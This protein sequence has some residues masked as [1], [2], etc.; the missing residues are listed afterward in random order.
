MSDDNDQ[1]KPGPKEF[2]FSAFPPNTAFHER[3]TGRE[4]RDDASRGQKPDT[5][6]TLPV[7]REHRT[8]KERRRRIDPTT[9]EKQY[10]VEETEFMNAMQRFKESTGKN[11][12]TYGEVLKVATALGYRRV[13]TDDKPSWDD[14]IDDAQSLAESSSID[15]LG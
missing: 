3:R 11:F 7:A 1:T 9:F 8:K 13:I 4:R 6:G 15:M 14:P 10:T 5:D 12:P 2:D